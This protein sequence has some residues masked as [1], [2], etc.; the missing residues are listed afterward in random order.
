MIQKTKITNNKN[1]HKKIQIEL[2]EEEINK[3]LDQIE[4]LQIDSELREFLISAIEAL[5]I[6]D[7]L[8]GMKETTIMRLRKIFNK[9]SEKT[10]SKTT[11][12]DNGDK[13]HPRGNNNG[14]NGKKDYPAASR[15]HHS[16]ES[17]KA[18]EICPECQKGTLSKY[19]P[20]IYIRIT[21]S[22]PL[23]ATVHETEKF[24]CN[25]CLTIFEASYAGKNA[26]KYDEGVHAIIAMLK[27]GASVPFYRL[28]KIQKHL[29]TPM[30][31]STQWD[32]M[33][34]LGNHLHPIW[35]VL[36][37]R[38]AEGN[39]F[40]IDDTK[41][42]VLSLLKENKHKSPER[43]GIF[44]TGIISETDEGKIILYLTGRKHAGENIDQIIKERKSDKRANLMADAL[45]ANDKS[46]YDFIRSHCLT[47]GRRKFV[48]HNEKFSE[49]CNFVKE[50]IANVYKNNKF[51]K[52]HNLTPSERLKYHQEHSTASMDNLK[53][54][55]EE[56]IAGKDIEPNSILATEI[57]YLLNHWDGLTSFLRV[58][59]AELDNNELEQKLRL[60]VLNRKNWL[61]YKTE[62]GA[63][64]GDI[65]CSFLKTCEAS[66]VNPF[67]YFVWVMN[68]KDLVKACPENYFP[69]K[70]KTSK[71]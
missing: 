24:R 26:P 41:A 1:L 2:T 29:H 13:P 18:G 14:K 69:W 59:G 60:Q 50:K 8:V 57:T 71:S 47:H 34:N 46:T 15:V 36:L 7:K 31:A 43:K 45:A 62:T 21:G 49:A 19:E 52:E 38:A 53:T 33:E 17:L 32:L 65:I 66:A 28:E 37:A 20:G 22:S 25:A 55:C 40:S 54:W 11:D 30:P 27:Y 9:Q 12:A 64:I 39:K 58:E 44:T 3:R 42:K 70:F 35:R 48:D 68:N 61:F 51:C 16:H 4:S 63:L 6:L 56:M 5:L 67:D 10:P 23:K